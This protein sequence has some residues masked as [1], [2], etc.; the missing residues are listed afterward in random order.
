MPGNRLTD[1]ARQLRAQQTDMERRLWQRLRAHRFQGH[2]FRRQQPIVPYIVDFVCHDAKLIIE[3]DGGQHA[4]A[5]AEDARRDAWLKA[6]GYRV[7]RIW[8]NE[9]LENETGVMEKILEML[10]LS[11]PPLPSRERG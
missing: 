2:K 6:E 3:L 7:L 11:P 8:N 4:E 10:T 9:W 1:F 5:V